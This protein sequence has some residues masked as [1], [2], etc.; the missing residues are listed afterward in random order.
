MGSSSV[1]AVVGELGREK[2]GVLR[3]KA[4]VILEAPD[5]AETGLLPVAVASE[6][7]GC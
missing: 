1:V 2:Q 3:G 6:G 4:G 7:V 5:S